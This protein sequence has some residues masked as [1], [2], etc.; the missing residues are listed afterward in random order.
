MLPLPYLFIPIEHS[1]LAWF[2]TGSTMWP[3]VAST[4]NGQC[5]LT[6]E[7][8]GVQ[9]HAQKKCISSVQVLDSNAM[10]AN[11]KKENL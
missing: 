10:E 4:S 6:A 7:L 8:T 5:L 1:A 11:L 3:T 2:E 9:H